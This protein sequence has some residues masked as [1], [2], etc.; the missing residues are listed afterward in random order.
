M[1][2]LRKSN[3]GLNIYSSC[4]K[5]VIKVDCNVKWINDCFVIISDSTG[6]SMVKAI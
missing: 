4:W 1:L 3:G 5:V 2:L 6:N